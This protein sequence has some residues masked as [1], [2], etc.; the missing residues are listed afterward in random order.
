MS[1]LPGM[2]SPAG[3]QVVVGPR[4]PPF[5]PLAGARRRLGP[6]RLLRNPALLLALT[7]ALAVGP[8]LA[9]DTA[10]AGT[11]A[12]ARLGTGLLGAAGLALAPRLAGR[13]G[14]AARL[15]PLAFVAL[16]LVAVVRVVGSSTAG[17][18]GLGAAGPHVLAAAVTI[19]TALRGVI[20]AVR[21]HRRP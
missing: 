12:V 18:A 16:Q 8:A 13:A 1:A 4:L 3:W 6:T 17:D 7:T 5:A 14:W 15:L 9:T 2:P 11:M 21:R 20:G 10:G 19:V